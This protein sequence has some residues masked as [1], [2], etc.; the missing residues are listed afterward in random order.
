MCA[1]RRRIAGGGV[2]VVRS[3]GTAR[4][5]DQDDAA[6]SEQVSVRH[7]SS[8]LA[9]HPHFAKPGMIKLDTDGHDADILLQAEDVLTACQPVVF[10][11]F[12][13][14]DGRRR[15]RHRPDCGSRSVGRSRL[16]PRAVLHEHRKPRRRARR[17]C[18]GLRGA[19]DGGRTSDPGVPW[20]TSTSVCSVPTTAGWRTRS[21]DARRSVAS[22]LRRRA[23]RAS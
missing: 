12:D 13:P 6:R 10:F 11:E 17:G 7:L 22:C 23:I 15:R 4:L 3:G 20:R 14:A 5:V 2:A 8:I 18:V 9:D 21:S 1:M 16:P 19:G